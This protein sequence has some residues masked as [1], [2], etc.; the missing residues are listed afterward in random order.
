MARN[1]KSW[2]RDS[3]L[4]SNTKRSCSWPHQPKRTLHKTAMP[5][6][7]HGAEILQR[8]QSTLNQSL[9]INLAKITMASHKKSHFLERFFQRT[10]RF[11]NYRSWI[12]PVTLIKTRTTSALRRWANWTSMTHKIGQVQMQDLLRRSIITWHQAN[13]QIDQTSWIEQRPRKYSLKMKTFQ[14]SHR[15]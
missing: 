2:S 12:C 3:W 8:T 9:A 10:S 14:T 15:S 5:K 6:I 4:S 7:R 1:R 11:R 13:G